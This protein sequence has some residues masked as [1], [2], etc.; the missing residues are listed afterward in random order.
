MTVTAI[1]NGVSDKYGPHCGRIRNTR[2]HRVRGPRRAVRHVHCGTRVLCPELLMCGSV[3]DHSVMT[4]I[5]ASGES[6][7]RTTVTS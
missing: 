2:R 3:M 7:N 1:V 4:M 6:Q 5:G